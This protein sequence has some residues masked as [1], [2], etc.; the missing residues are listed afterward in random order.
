LSE[1]G[2][3]ASFRNVVFLKKI[4][5]GQSSALDF[6]SGSLQLQRVWSSVA[7]KK[8]VFKSN[9]LNIP[10]PTVSFVAA[11]PPTK[12]STPTI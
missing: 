1:E 12:K 9:N 8:V 10:K 3:R 4:D 7:E 6:V 5:E 2:R 11:K